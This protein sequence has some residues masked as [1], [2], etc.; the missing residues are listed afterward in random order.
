MP[1]KMNRDEFVGEV[2]S[3][4]N[5]PIPNYKLEHALN[6]PL[7]AWGLISSIFCDNH[8]NLFI[9]LSDIILSSFETSSRAWRVK[10]T[11]Y[12]TQSQPFLYLL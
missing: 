10:S 2:S 7:R 8:S 6:F 9:T 11:L 5:L 1:N 4:N 3:I 12:F